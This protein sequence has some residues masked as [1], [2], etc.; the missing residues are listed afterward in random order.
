MFKAQSSEPYFSQTLDF[1]YI[2]PRLNVKVFMCL[3]AVVVGCLIRILV[4]TR[5]KNFQ[6]SCKQFIIMMSTLGLWT[7]NRSS[8]FSL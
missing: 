6:V 2:Q 4:L 8:A 5:A 1:L 7:A 3:S